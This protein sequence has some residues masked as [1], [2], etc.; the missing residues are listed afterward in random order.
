MNKTLCL[1]LLLISMS[2]FSQISYSSWVN[3]YLQI[4][5]YNGNTNPDAYTLTLAG[6]GNINMPYWRVSV[7]LKQP[8]IS[9]QGNYILPANKISFQPVS[10]SGKAYPNPV[11]SIPQIGMPLNVILK[12]NQEVFL[13]P[14]SN[15]ALFNQPAQP[16]GYYSL[17][18][19]YSMNLTGGTYLGAYPAWIT[20]TA[21]LQFTAYDQYN[22]IIGTMDHN[23]QFQI[24]TL[25][26]T[27]TDI[28]EMSMKFGA[29]AMNGSLEF[30]NMQDYV[31]GASVTYSNAL[32][33]KSN[34]KYQIKLKS[35]Q[36]QFSSSAGNFLPLDAVQLNLIPISGNMGTPY[37]VLLSTV[38]QL[39]AAGGSTQNADVYYDMKY[40]TKP[41][42]ERF[43]NAKAEDYT[44]TLQ[45]EITPQ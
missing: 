10:S 22:N 16:N 39:V 20:F 40:S 4:N 23:F 15:A 12:E 5:S 28:P 9:N 36:T 2:C 8:I 24:G 7:R 37:T 35:L 18:I 3:S 32:I 25:S 29:A 6:N 33:V 44:T 42:D 11:P 31:N 38:P 14:Q 27:P 1:I 26:G 43:I 34:T 21:P 17:Q 45:F 41:N 13:I 19:K 30:K